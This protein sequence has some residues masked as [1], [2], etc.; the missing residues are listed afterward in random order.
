MRDIYLVEPREH[1]NQRPKL[2][3]GREKCLQWVQVLASEVQREHVSDVMEEQTGEVAW[4]TPLKKGLHQK[5][6]GQW[7]LY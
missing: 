2:P 3:C 6:R 4:E 1:L 7:S 5:V